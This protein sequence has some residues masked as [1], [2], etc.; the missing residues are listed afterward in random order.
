MHKTLLPALI[1]GTLALTGCAR[2]SQVII[3]PQGIDMGMYQRDLA[4]C[5][6]IASQVK[7]RAGS[8][9]IGG[10]LIGAVVGEIIGGGRRTQVLSGLG[11]VK[12]AVRGGHSTVHERDRV[13]K[14]CLSDRGYR[15]LN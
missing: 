11:A 8:G 15:I 4:E 2:H 12:G 13:L 5:Q 7:S 6:Q 9:M 1:L 14:N 10:A 3:D